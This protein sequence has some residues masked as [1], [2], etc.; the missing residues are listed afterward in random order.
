MEIEKFS[1]SF[2]EIKNPTVLEVYQ[3]YLISG[4]LRKKPRIVWINKQNVDGLTEIAKIVAIETAFH[5]IL[6]FIPGGSFAYRL[7]KDQ[8]GYPP[9]YNVIMEPDFYR[10][11]YTVIT[12]DGKGEPKGV[13]DGLLQGVDSVAKLAFDTGSKAGGILKDLFKG[14]K[15]LKQKEEIPSKEEEILGFTYIRFEDIVTLTRNSIIRKKLSETPS[16]SMKL[17]K[18]TTADLLPPVV[19]NFKT[20]EN[21]KAITFLMALKKLGFQVDYSESLL[22]EIR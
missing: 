18:K 21:E 12:L 7:L 15:I 10:V 19:L 2:L 6:S 4:K 16:K 8:I 17:I 3:G 22:E 5:G 13:V 20:T 11:K 1:E 9:R 14:D